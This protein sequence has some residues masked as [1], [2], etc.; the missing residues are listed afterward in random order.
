MTKG[1]LEVEV[2]CARGI[3]E[4]P[5]PGRDWSISAKSLKMPMGSKI[6]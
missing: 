5:P 6:L 2:V 1:Q 4:D 3:K